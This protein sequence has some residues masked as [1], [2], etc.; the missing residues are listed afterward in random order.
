MRSIC[1]SFVMVLILVGCAGSKVTD[2]LEEEYQTKTGV[3]GEKVGL[4]DDKIMIQK[5][6]YLEEQ[7]AVLNSEVE[8]LQ[9]TIYGKSKTDPGGIWDALRRCRT[10]L[11]DPRVG[12]DGNPPAMEKWEEIGKL[13]SQF[14]H[15]VRDD[16][17]V[18]AVTEEA[19]NDR[20]TRLSK[21]KSILSTKYDGFKDKLD[22]C[23]HKYQTALVQHGLNPN[24][25]KANG[26]WVQ[27]PNGYKVWRMKRGATKDPE[28]LMRRKVKRENEE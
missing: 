6:V 25:T 1:L 4:K 16:K 19:L 9:H 21:A 7:L 27:G 17:N 11:A 10:R 8:D 3:D 18:I 12:G 28:E 5:R 24:D 20:I 26:E 15:T 23:E 13:D 22:T 14:E 2:K